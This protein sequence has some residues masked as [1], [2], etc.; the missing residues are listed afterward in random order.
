VNTAGVEGHTEPNRR[1]DSERPAAAGILL[2]GTALASL[3]VGYVVAEGHG[4]ILAG[5]LLSLPLAAWLLHRPHVGIAL[6]LLITPF[7]VVTGGG[8]LRTVYWLSH[9]LLP[10]AVVAIVLLAVVAG[11]N[12]ERLPRMGWPELA[13][14]AYLVISFFS[15]L[16]TSPEASATTFHLYDRVFIPMALYLGVRL[17]RPGE[18][19]LRALAPVF[20]IVLL[21]QTVIGMLSWMAPDVLPSA[22]SGRIGTRTTGSLRHPNVYGTTVLIAG[23]F[24]LH[25]VLQRRRQGS[26]P[27]VIVPSFVLALIMAFMTYSRATWLAAL[28]VLIG[29]TA[30][31]PRFGIRF[32]AVAGVAVLVLL[33]TGVIQEQVDR[34]QLRFRSEASEHSALSRLPVIYA[35]LHMAQERPL[36]GWGYGNFDQVSPSFQRRVGNFIVPDREHASHN[37][38][39]TILA[40]Q[41]VTGLFLYLAPVIY[42]L[43]ASPAAWRRLPTDGIMS[44][45]LLVVLWLALA[46]HLVVNNYSNMK[47]VYGLGLWWLTLG[48]IAVI[49][50]RY[51]GDDE[52]ALEL[53]PAIAAPAVVQGSGRA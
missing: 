1:E 33:S 19:E 11:I 31:Y 3:A 34:A 26:R 2:G 6:W 22:W 40:E 46:T 50:S 10:V 15:V 48:M 43:A 8:G 37:L 38:Y 36:F 32:L 21:S 42:W 39:L 44:R 27:P 29:V 7:V 18:A 17:L 25:L 52:P 24:L 16:H 4:L 49:V 5:L 35:S 30:I 45:K 47:V 53:A 20:A 23:L 9:R 51:R 14:A 41:G 13:M 12:R 28:V